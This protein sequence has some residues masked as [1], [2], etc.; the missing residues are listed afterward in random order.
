M[1]DDRYTGSGAWLDTACNKIVGY[2][3]AQTLDIDWNGEDAIWECSVCEG[4]YTTLLAADSCCLPGGEAIHYALEYGY[5]KGARVH[6]ELNVSILNETNRPVASEVFLAYAKAKDDPSKMNVD[7][8]ANLVGEMVTAPEV[9][10]LKSESV[11][12][13]PPGTSPFELEEDISAADKLSRDID[14]DAIAR[15]H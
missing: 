1:Y 5:L 10:P 14:F 3:D 2:A 13:S 12:S 4:E 11:E 6:I 9:L 15:K 7:D 8:L